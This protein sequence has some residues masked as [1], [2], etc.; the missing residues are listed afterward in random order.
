MVV[1]SIDTDTKDW[2]RNA[3][4][5]LAARNGCRFDGERGQFVVDWCAKYLRLYEG[6]CA[7]QPLTF[8]DWQYEA[9]MRMFGWIRS[10]TKW[11]R[12]VRRFKKASFWVPKKNKKS[13][14]LS[15]WGLYLLCADG[16]MGQKVFFGAKDGAQARQNCGRHCV[17]MVNASPELL[18]ECSI[19]LN[20]MRIT[21]EPTRSI[22][23]PLSSANAKTQKSKEG[24]NGSLL[25]DETH[26]VDWQFMDR[27]TRAGISRSEPLQIEVSTA[28]DDPEGYGRSR[29]ELGKKVE[30]GDV[31]DERMLFLCYEAPPGLTDKQLAADPLKY[32]RMS[33]PAWGHT[34]DPEEFLDDYKASCTS[35]RELASFKMYRLDMW[36]A[37]SNPAIRPEDWEACRAD[38]D[39]DELVGRECYAGFDLSLKWDTSALVLWFPW[40]T[41]VPEPQEGED[42]ATIKLPVQR[43]R[44]LTY[45]WL[46]EATAERQK[47]NIR[48]EEWSRDKAITLTEGNITDFRLIHEKIV[49]VS[50]LYEI[51]K[52][53][54]DER[55]AQSF[56]QRLQDEDAINV[57]S[58]G[59]SSTN[60]N[61]PFRLFE[62]MIL[63]KRIEH[64]GNPVMDWQTSQLS[65]KTVGELKMPMKP[66]NNPL[67]RIDGPVAAI[68]GLGGMLEGGED[69]SW[70]TPGSL[71]N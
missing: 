50:K 45:F 30:A 55:F 31:L 39:L 3:S 29:Y 22:L 4:D 10:S 71:R 28:G 24:L 35:L 63:D 9:T 70:Y 27:M 46:P 16:E 8:T 12:W 47:Q 43:Y 53:S 66:R 18:A 49:E 17:E 13:P 38:F 54:Y 41:M 36:Q 58:F 40:G 44:L 32:G 6:D 57:V 2:I 68:M 5:E 67:A 11:A 51:S 48:W 60:Y 26:V 69:D 25:I 21:H 65:F 42:P 34:I 23:H 20:E 56:C 15:G 33:N 62:T 37:A 14:T 61:E 59:Q 52:L 64:L 19:N 7:G 1:S